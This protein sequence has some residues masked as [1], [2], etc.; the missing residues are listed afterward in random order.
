MRARALAVVAALVAAWCTA[1]GTTQTE[2]PPRAI[3]S[4]VALQ[5]LSGQARKQDWLLYVLATLFIVRFA[6]LAA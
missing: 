3:T 4:Y 2:A 5:L 1:C 6:Y